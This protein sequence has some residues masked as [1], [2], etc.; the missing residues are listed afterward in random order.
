MDEVLSRLEGWLALP[1]VREVAILAATVVAAMLVRLVFGRL[2]AKLVRRTQSEVDDR[3]IAICRG[4]V[5]S[6]VVL[7][8][9]GLLVMGLELPDTVRFLLLGVL[10]TLGVVLVASTLIRIADLIVDSTVKRGEGVG[11]IQP[12]TAPLVEMVSKIVIF[13]GAVY[14][15]FVAWEIDLTTWLASA[16]IVGIAVGFAA[17]DTLANLFSG[18]FI[19]AD[20]PYKVGDFI[21]LDNG[22]RGQ[23]VDIGIRS[24]RILTRD[25]VEV[26]VPNAV[27]ASSK[28]VNETSGR[29][30]MMRVRVNVSVAY[31]SDVD[32]VR[33]I[34]MEC[35]QGV[36]HTVDDPTPRVR[37]REMGDSGLLFQ[38]L[39]WIDEPVFRGRVIDALN[40]RVYKA[41][42]AAGIEIPYPKQDIYI[43]EAPGVR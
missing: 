41:L 19:I 7:L 24:T 23:V 8:G 22:I 34:L 2:M 3:I 32:E 38:L 29:H 25:D 9:A 20:A 14:F 31:G 18:F 12:K 5:V 26:T 16:G 42:N 6:L 30:T 15:V 21:I 36:E 17:K 43:K 13:A 4:P 10:Q 11:L 39:V 27:I 37:F 35:T 1:G 28:I 40:T 33:R